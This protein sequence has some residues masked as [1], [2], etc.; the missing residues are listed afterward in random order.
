MVLELTLI[1]LLKGISCLPPPVLPYNTLCSD[2]NHVKIKDVKLSEIIKKNAD[3]HRL[4]PDLLAALIW[5]ESKG[6]RWAAR[7]EPGFLARYLRHLSYDQLPGLKPDDSYCNEATERIL[8]ATSLGLTQIMGETA[9][10][11]GFNRPCLLE[12]LTD[13]LNVEYGAK[14]LSR[15]IK[16]SSGNVANGL[17][18]YNGGGD[19]DYSRKVFA[20]L[21][22]GAFRALY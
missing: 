8:R 5:Q 9:R 3:E 12:L 7:H 18:R 15:C 21:K 16:N 4:S 11:L 6:N 19:P 17:R 22:T 2:Y 1:V 14:Y 13:E 10:E 20:H